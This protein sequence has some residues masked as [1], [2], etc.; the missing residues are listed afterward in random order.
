MTKNILQEQ[1]GVNCNSHIQAGWPF[2]RSKLRLR[3]EKWENTHFTEERYS[4][5]L[6]DGRESHK[7]SA[8]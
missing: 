6:V 3:N 5:E 8:E 4:K 2:A 7:P 1:S